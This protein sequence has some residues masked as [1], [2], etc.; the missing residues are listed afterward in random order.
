MPAAGIILVMVNA[1]PVWGD[2]AATGAR[3]GRALRPAELGPK[4]LDPPTTAKG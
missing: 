3:P 2:G 1:R 4:G